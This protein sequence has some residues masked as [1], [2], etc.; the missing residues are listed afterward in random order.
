[1]RSVA[2]ILWGLACLSGLL[3]AIFDYEWSL[4][5]RTATIDSSMWQGFGRW[6]DRS[7]FRGQAFG[8]QDVGLVPAVAVA[9][10]ALAAP[11]L[12][13]VPW[14]YRERRRLAF[15]AYLMLLTTV[16]WVH[17]GKWMMGRARPYVVAARDASWFTDWYQF[18]PYGLGD[19]SYSGSFP[20]GHVSTTLIL[21]ILVLI[22]LKGP[23][24]K[25]CIAIAILWGLAMIVGR[26]VHFQHWISDGLIYWLWAAGW[27]A[28]TVD[29]FQYKTL[30][31]GYWALKSIRATVGMA[32]FVLSILTL[33]WGL[34]DVVAAATG[35]VAVSA[36]WVAYK[37]GWL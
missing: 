15:A 18:G 31:S 37:K 26:V 24:R 16:V 4:M 10:L 20:S 19:G 32:L 29:S 11:W 9:L 23:L 12:P 36:W 28:W 30:G 14:L 22:W 33:R 7:W 27:V 25:V 21:W 13:S 3:L 6:M 2:W 34:G 1:M 8:G 35:V 17:G 5:A